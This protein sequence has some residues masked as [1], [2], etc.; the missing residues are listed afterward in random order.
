MT[1]DHEQLSRLLERVAT[2]DELDSLQLPAEGVGEV[3]HREYRIRFRCDR[4]AVDLLDNLKA[5]PGRYCD[6][7][8]AKFEKTRG[9]KSAMQV[10]DRFHISISGPWD[11]PVQVIA[12]E[13]QSYIFATMKDHLEAGFIRFSVGE[14][15]G[16]TEFA[17]ESW[18]ASAGPIV[19]LSYTGFGI[20]Q[21]MQTKMW[22]HYCLKVA[23]V[24]SGDVEGPLV[25]NTV[26]LENFS[27]GDVNEE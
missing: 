7:R 27:T 15:D 19:W 18:A 8:L 26:T 13:N 12:I 24:A 2:N 6:P 23:E 25:I 20:A 10:G 17:V 16:I 22:R 4:S 3:I 11:G 5:H 14:S 1:E 21:K 9:E